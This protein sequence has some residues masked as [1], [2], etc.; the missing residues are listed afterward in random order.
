MTGVSLEFLIDGS[1]VFTSEGRWLH[2]LLE[3]E[4]FLSE[5]GLEGSRGEIR[6]KV[7]GRASAFLIVGMGVR[8]VHAGL[9][10]RLGQDVLDRAGVAATWD[11]LVDEI[12][13]RTEG[14][15]RN[16][17]DGAEARRII[18]QRAE[19]SGGPRPT[20]PSSSSPARPSRGN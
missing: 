15:L 3:L 6:D 4:Q 19:A 20:P 5:R 11:R 1:P 8:R 2:P 18:V 7:V 17:T 13:C 9:L 12:E 16:V 14:L 10:S